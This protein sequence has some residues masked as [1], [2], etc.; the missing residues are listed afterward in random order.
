MFTLFPALALVV[1]LLL[2]AGGAY[3]ILRAIGRDGAGFSF[4]SV[5][6]VYVAIVSGVSLLVFALG[7]SLLLNAGFGSL[8][9]REFSY[10]PSF[11]SASFGQSASVSVQAPPPPA[12]EQQRTSTAQAATGQV[13]PGPTA[14]P[15]PLPTPVIATRS[16][17][18]PPEIRARQAVELEQQQRGGLVQGSSLAVTGLLLWGLHRLVRRTVGPPGAASAATLLGRTSAAV[19]LATF[20][21]IGVVAVPTAVAQ[22]ASY[23]LAPPPEGTLPGPEPPGGTLA[24]ALVALPFWAYYLGVVLRGVRQAEVAASPQPA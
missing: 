21:L 9:G 20:S 12:A 1:L 3:V 15:A 4:R 10:R 19:M 18:I 8:L 14:T 5:L 24:T 7:L 11:G 2:L 13:T 16:A 22:V 23:F 6:A 17:T